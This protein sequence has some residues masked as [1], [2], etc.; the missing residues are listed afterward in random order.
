VLLRNSVDDYDQT[1]VMVTHD[2]GAAAIA[3]RVLFLAD[4]LLVRDL[5]KSSQTEILSAMNEL[6]PDA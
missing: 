2:A 5:G 6:T 4:G 1:M 3:D